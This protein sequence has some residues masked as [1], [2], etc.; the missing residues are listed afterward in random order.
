MLGIPLDYSFVAL[1]ACITI[2]RNTFFVLIMREGFLQRSVNSLIQLPKT[3]RFYFYSANNKQIVC[4]WLFV[5]WQNKIILKNHL[6]TCAS[7]K[8]SLWSCMCTLIMHSW[9]QNM[10]RAQKYAT[11]RRQVAWLMFLPLSDILCA[12]LE[13]MY[14]RTAKWN[15][16]VLCIVLITVIPHKIS[17]FLMFVVMICACRTWRLIASFMHLYFHHKLL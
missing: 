5:R 11:S 9:C 17:I 15:I 13:Y 10:V 16:F 1:R 14:K 2:M 4:F 6:H 8:V 3:S 7:K 12:F